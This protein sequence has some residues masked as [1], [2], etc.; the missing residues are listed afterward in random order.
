MI[1]ML[2]GL[3]VFYLFSRTKNDISK[4]EGKILLLIYLLFIISQVLFP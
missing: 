2:F 4:H 3:G 1:L